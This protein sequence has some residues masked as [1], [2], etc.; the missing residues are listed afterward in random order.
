MIES[1]VNV[2]SKASPKELIL[3]NISRSLTNGC[4]FDSNKRIF[5]ASATVDY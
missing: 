1:N 3:L 2:S 5:D 4:S